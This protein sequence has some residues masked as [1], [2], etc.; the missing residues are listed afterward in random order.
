MPNAAPGKP[1]LVSPEDGA[2]DVKVNV[3]FSWREVSD[4]DGD[5]VSYKLLISK[6]GG[7]SWGNVP[8]KDASTKYTDL[9]DKSTDYIWKVEAID[10]FGAKTESETRTFTTGDGGAYKDG[11]I[12]TYQMESAGAAKPIHLVFMGDGFIEDDYQEGG[13][14][15]QAVEAAVEAL[16]KVEPYATYR[17]YFRVSTVAVYSQERGATVL[18]DMSTVKVQTRNTAFSATLEGGKSTGTSCNYDKVYSYALKV[19]GVTEEVLKNTTVFLL[20]NVDAYAGTCAMELGGRSV[21]MCSM[22]KDSFKPVVIH[23]GGG[24]GFGRLL[25]EYMYTTSNLPEETKDQI[26]YWRGYDPYYGYNIDLTGDKS[27][28]HWAHYFSRAGYEAVGMY[29]GACL[30]TMGVWRPEVIS[31]MDDNRA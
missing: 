9:L 1:V 28:V 20:I 18:K 6:D 4:P 23:E 11:E 27:K 13:A 2:K 26:T 30:Y 21:S 3:V 8:T 22:G 10:A 19:P 7:A 29:E 25:D 24:H 14:F 12:S 17:N 5:P 31:C 16:F 15:D